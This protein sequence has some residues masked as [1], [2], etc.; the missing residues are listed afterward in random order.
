ML[1][2][3]PARGGSKRIPGKNVK[4]FLGIP[5]IEYS[6]RAAFDSGCFTRVLV[7]TDSD[8]IAAVARRAGAD[9]PFMR[10]AATADDYATTADVVREV[11]DRLHGQG[12]DYD[13]FAVI[14]ATAPFITPDTLRRGAAA[15]ADGHDAAFTC[16]EYSY[17]VQRSLLIRDGLV[18]MA[19]PEYLTARSQDLEKHYH[20]AGQCYFST[21][22]AF[23]DCGS[24]WGPD[25]APLLL[26]DLEVQDIDTPVDWQLAELKYRLLHPEGPAF[27]AAGA[28]ETGLAAMPR[29]IGP[30]RFVP[31]YE[32]DAD[33]SERMRCGRN[34]P[35]IRSRMVNTDEIDSASHAAFV[36]SLRGRTDKG[37]F[38]IYCAY[39]DDEEGELIGSLTLEELPGGNVERGVWLF[40]DAR[41]NGYARAVMDN[42]YPQLGRM[43]YKGIVTR[44]RP[45][46]DASL[47]LEEYLGA[48]PAESPDDMLRFYLPMSF[49]T[50]VE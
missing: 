6:I 48:K 34:L 24:L 44:V 29:R 45:D 42:L 15:L 3:I 10:S 43:G 33:T 22:A 38:A 35:D 11:L 18:S 8:E 39:A 50:P 23:R 37:Y 40:P 32:L 16:V 4:P 31:Y 5:V 47:R 12:E 25:T 7:S 1:A 36:D 17:P 13:A 49:I 30:F 21:V 9:V 19:H 41:G 46:N 27:A 20:D 14:Y 28:P 2:I 26:S